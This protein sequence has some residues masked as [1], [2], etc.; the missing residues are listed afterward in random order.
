M[1]DIDKQAVKNGV[2]LFKMVFKKNITEDVFQHKHFGNPT[3]M[4]TPYIVKSDGDKPIAMR[5]MMKLKFVYFGESFFGVQ[6]SDDAVIPQKRG[7]LFLKMRK[8]SIN[9]MK[10]ENVCFEYGLFT[11]GESMSIAEK[12]GEKS[13]VNLYTARLVLSKRNHLR[14]LFPDLAINYINN[15]KIKRLAKMVSNDT[16]VQ[17]IYTN[18]FTDDDYTI[19][20]KSS[21]LQIE[22]TKEYYDWKLTGI[23]NITFITAR[24]GKELKGYLILIKEANSAVLID[25]DVFGNDKVVILSA[26]L[27]PVINKYDHI[28]VPYVNA[29]NYE[30][31]LFT[32]IGCED[33]RQ[34]WSTICICVNSFDKEKN[35]VLLDPKKWKHRLIDSDYFLNR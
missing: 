32:E 29:D 6:S 24:K 4:E 18:P 5:W 12:S 14:N 10:A 34:W 7:L 15:W 11:P 31:S 2:T 17:V 21:L 23:D 28:D 30:M 33:I 20:N 22:R 16:F 13:V 25:W 19:I 26:M 35:Q 9:T 3:K 8:E 1:K 27:I